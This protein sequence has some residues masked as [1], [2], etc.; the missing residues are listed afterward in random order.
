MG[1][2]AMTVPVLKALT[3]QYPDIKITMLTRGFFK[4]MFSQLPNVTIYE[5]DLNG[6][7][8]GVLGLLKLYK[9]LKNLKIDAVADLH[10]VLRSNILKFYFK[11]SKIPFYQIDKGRNEKKALTASKQKKIIQLKTT[12]KR[13]SDVFEKLGFKIDLNEIPK[14]SK[15]SIAP[16]TQKQLGVDTKK[17][18][19]IAPFAAFKGKMYPFE[20]MEHVVNELNNT[21]KYKIILFGGGDNEKLQLDTWQNKYSNCINMTK[22]VSFSEELAIISQLDLMLAMDSGNA[23]IAAIYQIPTVTLWGVTHPFAGFYP[24]NQ[25][26]TNAL[27]ADREKFPLIPTSI[28]GNKYPKGYEKA[29]ETITPDVILNKIEQVL[30]N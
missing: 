7:H 30:Y 9:E 1:D 16:E 28:Y 5:P 25:N 3:Q 14:N 26:P 17:W 29:M 27:L 6:K 8:K 22:R 18:I 13:Y 12:H 11:K 2:V 21:G 24:F 23:H 10:N 15:I 4:P 20:L 19:G